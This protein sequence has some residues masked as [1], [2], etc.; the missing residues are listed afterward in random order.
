MSNKDPMLSHP[1]FRQP[2]QNERLTKMQDVLNGADTQSSPQTQTN[3]MPN[4]DL[5]Q[6]IYL[7]RIQDKIEV[8]GYVFEMKT[9]DSSE[10]DEI[11]MGLSFLPGEN[12]FLVIKKPILVRSITAINGR[13]LETLYEGDDYRELTEQQRATRVVN[14]WQNALVN[15]LYEFYE[16]LLDRSNK[17]INPEE[18]KK[19]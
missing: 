17:L 14:K 19:S 16:V 8:G 2:P 18:V 6:L 4:G 7:G 13:A 12:K 1:S 3:V 15:K 10:Q 11:W 5:R 9:L